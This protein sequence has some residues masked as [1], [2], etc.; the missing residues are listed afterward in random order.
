MYFFNSTFDLLS[1]QVSG[2]QRKYNYLQTMKM[3]HSYIETD[4]E[5]LR[6]VFLF[7]SQKQLII[8]SKVKLEVKNI[9]QEL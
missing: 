4:D 3:E 5:D 8:E 1:S 7:V 6:L 9:G 2:T